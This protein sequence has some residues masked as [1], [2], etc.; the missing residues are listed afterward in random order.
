MNCESRVNFGRVRAFLI[1]SLIAG[2]DYSEAQSAGTMNREQSES[3]L[4]LAS[5]FLTSCAAEQIRLAA[6]KCKF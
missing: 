1:R 6:D 4:G 3:Y 2:V 5:A